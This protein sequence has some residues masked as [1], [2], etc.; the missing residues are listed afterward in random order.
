ML[1]RWQV[2]S[3]TQLCGEL[4]ALVSHVEK[5]DVRRCCISAFQM[6]RGHGIHTVAISSRLLPALREFIQQRWRAVA[7]VT[8]Q[9][10][11]GSPGSGCS[12]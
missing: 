12:R 9:L 8:I 1:P 3:M 7:P 4:S 10:H 11:R 6:A 2:S 5:L